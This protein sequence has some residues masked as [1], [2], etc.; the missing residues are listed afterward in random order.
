MERIE[1][2]ER[3]KETEKRYREIQRETQ[4]EKQKNSLTMSAS[5]GQWREGDGC[6]PDR[7]RGSGSSLSCQILCLATVVAGRLALGCARR[8]ANFLLTSEHTMSPP[9]T[10]THAHAYRIALEATYSDSRPWLWLLHRPRALLAL[11]LP[12]RRVATGTKGGG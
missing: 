6:R 1:E 8:L 5:G 10:H 4:R 7:E 12:A 9:P 3:S 11:P 2:C